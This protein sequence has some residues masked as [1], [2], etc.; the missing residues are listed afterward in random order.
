MS[1]ARITPFIA[2]FGNQPKRLVVRLLTRGYPFLGDVE[3]GVLTTKLVPRVSALIASTILSLLLC[4]PVSAQNT[5]APLSSFRIEP[6]GTAFDIRPFHE[7][8]RAKYFFGALKWTD[9]SYNPK[10]YSIVSIIALHK[11]AGETSPLLAVERFEAEIYS[12]TTE[13]VI[14]GHAPQINY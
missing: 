7:D 12:A 10:S 8:D 2:C 14:Y 11:V 6:A 5:L 9:P 1:I 13:V 3:A 4:L